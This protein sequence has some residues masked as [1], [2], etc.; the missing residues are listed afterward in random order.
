MKGAR[1]MHR[2]L[3]PLLL[4]LV[5]GIGLLHGQ[6]PAD[7]VERGRD[8]VRGKPALNPPVWSRKAFDNLWKQ[9]GLKE[10]PADYDEAVR[11]RY[12]LLPAAYDNDGLPMGLHSSRGL[13][14][15]GVVNDCL[16][17]HASR[18]AGQTIIGLGN[19]GLDLQGLFDDL[20]AS[21]GLNFKFPFRFSHSRGT[22]NVIGPTNFLMGFRDPDLNVRLKPIELE[23]RDDGHSDPPAWWL[24]KRK[25]T[26]DWNGGIDARSTRADMVNLLTPFNSGDYIKKQAPIFADMHAFL[27]SV[28]APKYPFPIDQQLAARG[29]ELFEVSCAKC[30]GTYGP[31]GKY[32]NKIVDIDQIG[33]DPA[34]AASLTDKL[35]EHYNQSWFAR[36]LAPDGK[37]M[38]FTAHQGYQ[39]PP[40]DGVW[41]T[42]PYLHNA[43]VPTVYH[44]LNSKARPK[45]F[46]RSY[47]TEKEDYDPV[48]LGWKVQVLEGPPEANL[49]GFERR[50]IY[51]TSRPGRGNGGHLFG[52]D[53]TD[54]ERWA[55]IE[56]LKTL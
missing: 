51:D 1:V 7:P 45:F 3:A 35:A 38:R 50:K 22:V 30:H 43:S 52:D 49:S 21:E 32:P 2:W 20:T 36:E 40:L 18:I 23:T 14:G 48:K 44:L 13:V 41:A 55:V 31:G 25:K 16:M 17:C 28:E 37:P 4:V 54:E 5:C 33:T 9:W 34:L 47:R 8:A 29:K 12:G 27:L 6:S 15:K 56:Y 24:L 39:A 46:S 10:K 42:A 26:R 53:L 11:Q 19:A